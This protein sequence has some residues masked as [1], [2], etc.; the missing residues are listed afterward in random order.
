MPT[1][2]L[3]FAALVAALI[4]TQTCSAADVAPIPDEILQHLPARQ[5]V[6]EYPLLKE[7][8]R[9]RLEIQSLLDR[10]GALTRGA[11]KTALT[12]KIHELRT[13]KASLSSKDMGG[14]S[15]ER[16][17]QRLEQIVALLDRLATGEGKQDKPAQAKLVADIR[18]LIQAP[19]APAHITALN[20]PGGFRYDN[21][22]REPMPP[23][24]NERPAYA[25]KAAYGEP[26]LLALN[27]GVEQLAAILPAQPEAASCGWQAADLDD[28]GRNV[29][30]SQEVRDLA[31]K[32]DYSPA[33]ILEWVNREIKLEPYYGAL[34]GSTGTLIAKSGGSTDIASL[35]IALLR[36]SNVP[37]RYVKAQVAVVDPAVLEA[38]G[39]AP[40]WFGVKSYEATV[41]LLAKGRVPGAETI[42]NGTSSTEKLGVRFTHVLVE[43]CVPYAHYR[44]SR[45]DGLGTRWVPLDPSFR[46]PAYQPGISTTS[47]DLDYTTYLAKR[48]T[49][50]PH[51]RYEKEVRDYLATLSPSRTL[52]EVPYAA[53][54]D[55]LKIDVL[56]A[57]LP[58]E[59]D[60][61]INWSNSGKPD[62]AVLPDSHQYRLEIEVKNSADGS[63]LAPV[64]LYMP[65]IVLKRLTLAF[66][67]A[68]PA[69][70]LA[71][72]NWQKDGSVDSALPCPLSVKPIISTD[73]TDRATGT[74]SVDLCSVGNKLSMKLMLDT[75]SGFIA[76]Q[77]AYSNID[78]ANLHALQTY[79]FQGSDRHLADRVARLLGAVRTHAN[80]NS[81]PAEVEGEFLNIVG[82]KFMRYYSDAIERVG[83]LAGDT[84]VSGNH[85]GLTSTQAKVQYAFDMPL[86]VSRSGYLVDVPGGQFGGVDLVTGQSVPKSFRLA[87]YAGSAL[88][89]YIW[90]ENARL[91]AVST[92]RGLQFAKEQGITV[93]D[94]TYT[95]WAAEKA[96]LLSGNTLNYSAA[97]VNYLETQ[98][99][100]SNQGYT[101]KIPRGKIE[102]ENWK[103]YIYAAEKS[104]SITMGISGGYNGGY[105]LSNPISYNYSPILNTGYSYYTPPL[106]YTQPP[107]YV[108]PPPPPV[109]I[110]PAI[111]LGITPQ[112]TFGGDPVN[113][114]NGNLYHNE[115]DI[116]IKGRG[117]LDFVFE[118][119]YNSRDAKDGPL[120]FGWTHSL[121]HHLVFADD[122]PNSLTA[123]DDN[124]NAVSS[125][126]WVD[127]SGSR[128]AIAIAINSGVMTFTTPTG[129]HFSV[130]RNASSQFV[131][132]ETNGFKYTFENK[133][134]TV[135]TDE[136]A[137]WSGRAR[138]LSIEDRHGN[139]LDLTY[140]GDLLASVKDGLNR[141][142]TFTHSGTRISEIADWTGRKWQY[143][144]TNGDLTSYKNPRAAV[145]KQPG[146]TYAYF[147]ETDGQYL[148]H[149]MKQYLLPR[150]NGMAFEYYIN[151]RVFRH[152][153]IARPLEST[154]FSYNDFR[155][156]TVVT[157]ARGNTKRHFFDRFG[158]PEKIHDEDG[159]ET[160]YTYDC[161]ST[162]NSDCPNPYNR[163]SETDPTGLKIENSYDTAGN[164]IKTRFPAANTQ[165]ERFDFAATTFAQPRRIKD[166]RGNWTVLKYDS[167]GRITD[168]IR[169]KAG[170]TAASCATAECATPAAADIAAW[171]QRSFDSYGNVIQL[172]RLRDFATPAGPTL[173]TGWN[174]TTNNVTGLNPV[175][176]TRTG[177]KDGNGT[178]DTADVATQTFDSLGRLK[179][180]ID[181][182]WYAVAVTEY[183]EVDR[184]ARQTDALGRTLEADFDA[185]GNQT[186]AR[187]FKNGILLDRSQTAYDDADRAISRADNAGHVTQL[188]YDLTGNVIATTNPDGYTV[189][190]AYDPQGRLTQAWDA[191]GYLA[192]RDYDIGGRLQ[193]VTDAA[194]VTVSNTYHSAAQGG[195][196]KRSNLPAI[197]SATA[198]RASEADYDAAGN[199][200]KQRS[201]GS[202]SATREHLAW[203][204]EHNRVVREVSPAVDA[205]RRQICRKYS[206]LGDLTE[207]WVGATADTSSTVCNFAD[208]NLKKQV[209]Y[210]Y[211]DFGR[212]LRETDPLAKFWAWTYDKHGNV[213]TQLDA[214]AQTTTFTWKTGGLPDTR[215]DHANR[216]TTWTHDDLGQV[217]TVGDA[218]V[219]YTYAYDDAHRVT[220]V[221]DSRGNKTLSYAYSPGGLLNRLTDSEGH[222]TDYLYDPVGRLTGQWLP[223][224]AY[225]AWG[226]NGRGQPEWKWSDAGILTEYGWNADGSL[227][228]LANDTDNGTLISSDAYTYDAFGRRATVLE[229]VSGN[230]NQY[231]HVYDEMGRLRETWST[232]IAP[233][234]GTETRYRSYRYDVFGNRQRQ[235][236][237]NGEFDYYWYD[238]AQQL[239]W[240]DRYNAA[241]QFQGT[242]AALSH[243][244]NGSLTS[245]QT[246]VGTLTLTWDESNQLKTASTGASAFSQS[247]AY[248]PFGRRISKTHTVVSPAST[249]T[250]NY[251]YDGSDIH[252]EY[253]SWSQPQAL[254]AHGQG[255]DE[256]LA[257]LPLT[258]GQFDAARYYHAD[259][260]GTINA[261]TRQDAAAA[262]T[263]ES[264]TGYDAWGVPLFAKDTAAPITGYGWKGRERDE[265]GLMYFRARYYD[266]AAMSSSTPVGRFVSRDPIGF[267]GGL[268]PYAAFENDPANNADPTGT[269][270]IASGMQSFL[271]QN[272][273]Y[274]NKVSE[275]LGFD[276]FKSSNQ[277]MATVNWRP[278]VY[279][280]S[281]TAKVQTA[282]NLASMIPVVGAPFALASA[283]I[284][285]DAGHYASAG[286][287]IASVIPFL[288]TVRGV[289]RAAD[290]LLDVARI[291]RGA[292]AVAT[293][294]RATFLAANPSLEGQVV[295]HHAVEQQVLNRYPGVM[296]ETEIH[297]LSNLRG[298][299][300]DLNSS[301]HLSDIRKSWNQFYRANS[302]P[303][304]QDFLNH[305]GSI[306]DQYGHLFAPPIR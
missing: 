35:T 67:G 133:A 44:G 289:G 260:Q 69:A 80:P 226:Y 282:L 306:D 18:K 195:R 210:L 75:L 295:V 116:Q 296:T 46:N 108:P 73:G 273:S 288:G 20:P 184:I 106:V 180:G 12:A 256:A 207:L 131:V 76:N 142:L 120:G 279:Q 65:D 257:R 171:T 42:P 284:D 37:A 22:P 115:R 31:Q 27:G 121:N 54:P 285:A 60:G 99:F 30:L 128:K 88:E 138:L 301:L 168:E 242:L 169:L 149:M 94:L 74:G 153:P 263:L 167:K 170:K 179:T 19:P 230:I 154:T 277:S 233:T 245:K 272:N 135:P 137:S 198:G 248:D 139:K 68:T 259:G 130:T 269:T 276:S 194:G 155:R 262:D 265:T 274:Y 56:P 293:D 25:E 105:T 61:F 237:A 178:L 81:A 62:T 141:T 152:A 300:N 70:Q 4:G 185:N 92:V 103:G 107:V 270:A 202:D 175:S 8:E 251:L 145:N 209:T 297:S 182:S 24:S 261:T 127:G 206:N 112:S 32:L 98:F 213:L 219:T 72:E 287:G 212:R 218:N 238:A 201:V 124:D 151:G 16:L 77:A 164:L 243:D 162:D 95:N 255:V 280:Q 253:Q 187:I 84:G 254:Y 158:N 220:S 125:I 264:F 104:G 38:N 45:L 291:E 227:N 166:V 50:L 57:S 146:V 186:E 90:Q 79:A 204:D 143:G 278:S 52:D 87:T 119:A 196:L 66:E 199:V 190:A 11:G 47:K 21:P 232:P 217:L 148:G 239:N 111:G 10:P 144:Y 193:S 246:G 221:T 222:L 13:L 14:L 183:D 247:Y 172:K 82:L 223:N 51:E 203:Y 43:A 225:I 267:A 249:T 126:V 160:V 281:T 48:G 101:V 118:R 49:D 29:V 250:T 258:S 147:T 191:E 93:L 17:A 59:V 100:S 9:H 271:A 235:T 83:E 192:A 129:F 188:E 214:K 266:S 165:V 161:R 39:K 7:I 41:Q 294:Y 89:S 134:A 159:A 6:A 91:D 58:Y 216:I 122:N 275:Q 299:P 228:G 298:I 283:A 34:K 200:T 173:D 53:K 55:S 156:E 234:A 177:D 71:L 28:D 241:S 197:Q 292:G 96:K 36:A 113:L 240:I 290:A 303:T 205:V 1:L 229:K 23:R 117:G 97:E 181:A 150:G 224:D 304:K 2:K 114:V 252:A 302:T 40:R 189:E 26:V 78:A 132:T 215:K 85:L 123:A 140:S 231:R 15:T 211:D 286:L 174:D 110:S 136:A 5:A 244:A 305:A 102:Y 208:A 176:L 163:L 157:D 236:Q 3:A 64:S 63:L 109:I 268:N 86:G 33:R